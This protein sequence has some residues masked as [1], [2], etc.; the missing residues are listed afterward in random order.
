M[1]C[2]RIAGEEL[3]LDLGLDWAVSFGV[4]HHIPDPGPVM[5]R[6]FSALRPGGQMLAWLYGR[7]GNG[8]YLSIA[9]PLRWVTTRLPHRVLVALTGAL[10]IPLRGY[11]ALARAA[12]VPMHDYMKNHLGMLAP[13]ARRLTIYDQLNPAYARY[14]TEAEARELFERAGFVDVRTHHRHGYSWLVVGRRPE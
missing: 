4:L 10:D 6:A 13:D 14:Y 7:E 9:Q 2:L 12:P 11:I 8:L 5:R 3:P 1:R